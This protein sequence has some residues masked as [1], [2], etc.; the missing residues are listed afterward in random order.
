MANCQTCDILSRQALMACTSSLP[1]ER[2]TIIFLGPAT[3]IHKNI[4]LVGS[5]WS[6]H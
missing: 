6:I 3:I 4:I 5:R 1:N 2:Y